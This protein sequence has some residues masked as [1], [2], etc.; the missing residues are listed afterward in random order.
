[1]SLGAEFLYVTDI[2]RVVSCFASGFEAQFEPARPC[3]GMLDAGA[4]ESRLSGT[5][6]IVTVSDALQRAQEARRGGITQGDS[7]SEGSRS[8]SRKV[9]RS[10][11]RTCA[12]I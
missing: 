10:T 3:E 12:L 1:M 7:A 9:F 6:R 8:L 4:Q 5:G 11:R 2:L